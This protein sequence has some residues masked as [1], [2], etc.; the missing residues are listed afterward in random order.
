[1]KKPFG[2]K[3]CWITVAV[4][5]PLLILGVGLVLVEMLINNP[6]PSAE[7]AFQR[8]IK[9]P[10]PKSV[11]DLQIHYVPHMR[12]YWMYLVF[13]IAPSD[14]DLLYDLRQFDSAVPNVV[15]DGKME[16]PG[17]TAEF[18]KL[19]PDEFT[20]MMIKGSHYSQGDFKRASAW[21]CHIVVS[22]DHRKV[23]WFRFQD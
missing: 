8:Y 3:W 23:Y 16:Y 5:S 11:T 7:E 13:R 4:A 20:N 21:N 12:G 18:R 1:M 9:T 14:L 22:S 6:S 17:W 2:P 10:I 15:T 19:D